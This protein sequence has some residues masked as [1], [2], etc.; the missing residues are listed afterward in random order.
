MNYYDEECLTKFLKNNH[1]NYTTV[2]TYRRWIMPLP[3]V[4]DSL[5]LQGSLEGYAHK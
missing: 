5:L 4:I 3:I 1:N 2:L